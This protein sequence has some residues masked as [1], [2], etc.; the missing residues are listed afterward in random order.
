MDRRDFLKTAGAASAWPGAA[1]EQPAAPAAHSVRDTW[2]AL[3]RR[4]AD[5]VLTNLAGGT[6][7]ARMP[8]EQAAGADRRSVTHLE[9]LGRLAAGMAP[10]L[11]LAADDTVEGQSREK[12]RALALEAIAHAVDPSSADFLNFTRERQPLVDAA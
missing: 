2:I 11:E 1:P 5:P 10:W 4:L 6:L 3:M 8:V 9:A 7:K 12:Y